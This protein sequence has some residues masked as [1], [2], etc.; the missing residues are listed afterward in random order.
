MHS[1]AKHLNKPKLMYC[2]KCV[3]EAYKNSKDNLAD[4]GE[5]ITLEIRKTENIENDLVSKL[6][7]VSS[8]IEES[9]HL[10]N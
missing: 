4:D 3:S 9:S 10:V 6:Q 1:I 7:K 8:M 2:H 5:D